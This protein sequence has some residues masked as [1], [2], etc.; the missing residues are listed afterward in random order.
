MPFL[1]CLVKRTEDNKLV[2]SVY[3]KK[4]HTEQYS[5][6]NSNQPLN[7]KL[8]TIKALT[9]RASVICSSKTDL[10]KEVNSIKKTMALN[11]FPQDVIS[12]TIT[13]TLKYQYGKRKNERVNESEN[14]LKIYLP[15]EK[16]ISER[17]S[18]LAKKFHVKIVHKSTI[19]LKQRMSFGTKIEKMEMEGVVY[20]V[21][22]WECILSYI[23]ET[24]RKLKTRLEEHEGDARTKEENKLSGLSLHVRKNRS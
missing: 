15:Y 9:R 18:R 14:D 12:K 10:K 13:E 19:S 11:D 1:D 20:K 4:T 23:G 22:C 8:S 16:G 5:N 21:K 24:G 7:V 6:F 3:K 17:L 2:T